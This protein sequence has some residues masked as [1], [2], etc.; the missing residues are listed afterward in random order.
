MDDICWFTTDLREVVPPNKS[1][2]AKKRRGKQPAPACLTAVGQARRLAGRSRNS[3]GR[4]SLARYLTIHLPEEL[5]S[6]RETFWASGSCNA[7]S[8]HTSSR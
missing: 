5:V 6:L 4:Q 8:Q 1:L 7:A 3:S 2:P